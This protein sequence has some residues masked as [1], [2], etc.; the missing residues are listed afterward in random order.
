MRALVVRDGHVE[1]VVMLSD[2]P[3]QPPDG[4]DLLTDAPEYVGLGWS[5]V[6]GEW[7]DP[8]PLTLTWDDVRSSRDGLLAACDWTM[9]ADAPLDEPTR[10]AWRDYRQALRDVPETFASPD[11]VVWPTKPS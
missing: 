4:T 9:A 8:A 5:L 7:L 1:N 3:W 6:D 10:E 2:A 11:D